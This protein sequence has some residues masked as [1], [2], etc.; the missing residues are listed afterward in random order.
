MKLSI[1]QIIKKWVKRL[2]LLGLLFSIFF[3]A[4][5]VFRDMEKKYARP[6]KLIF[7]LPL[8]ANLASFHEVKKNPKIDKVIIAGFFSNWDPKDGHFRMKPAGKG[9]WSITLRF[10]PGENQYKYVVYIKGRKQ[11]VWVHDESNPDRVQDGFGGFNSVQVIPNVKDT[12]FIFNVAVL[13]LAFLLLLYYLIEPLLHWVLRLKLAFRFKLVA[14]MIFIVIFS[15]ILFIGY[16][17]IESR[18][19]IK[20]G[21]I[22]SLNMVHLVL[23]GEGINFDKLAEKRTQE[24]IRKTVKKFFWNAR[25][26]VEKNKHSNTQVSLSDIALLDTRFR[27]LCLMNRK[28]NIKQQ[29]ARAG[30]YGFKSKEEFFLKGVLGR[31]VSAAKKSG[32]VDRI[33]L[34]KSAER[35]L[36]HET[37]KTKNAISFL[38]YNAFLHPIMIRG[39]L[40]GYYGGSIQVK[41]FGSELKRILWFNLLLLVII[42]SLA[43]M[44]LVSVGRVITGYLSELAAWTKRII[45][46]DFQ[47]AKTINSRDEIQLLAENFDA[48][49]KSL[50][51][52]FVKIEKSNTRLRIEAFVDHMTGLPN[53]QKLL[54]DLIHQEHEALLLFNID[55]FRGLN[56]FFGSDIGDLI[57]I[58]LA[59]RLAAAINNEELGLYK[60][61]ADD[62]VI[63]VSNELSKKEIEGL[64]A[65]FCDKAMDDAYRYLENEIYISVTCGIALYQQGAGKDPRERQSILNRADLALRSAKKNMLRHLVFDPSMEIK[66]EYEYNIQWIKKLKKAIREDRLVPFFQPIIN[67]KNKKVEKFECLVR[68]VE[69]DGS[70]ILPGQFLHV[71]KKARFYRFITRIMFEKSFLAFKDLPYEFSINVSMEDIM[72]HKTIAYLL[73]KLGGNPEIADRLI[74]E[75]VETAEIESYDVVKEF[76]NMVKRYGC[77]IAID[78]FGAGYSNFE[79]IMRLNI[80]FLKIDASL[81]RNMDTDENSQIITRTI[82]KFAKELGIK[83]IA[84]FVH[85]DSIYK[86]TMEY[87]IDYSQGYFFGKPEAE[88]RG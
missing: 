12:A 16:H 26:R 5:G 43:F 66:R 33:R 42:S 56:D 88:I 41:L 17:F 46:G 63:A 18:H 20:Q 84:E 29:D 2:L 21:I 44:L 39:R 19:L 34:G 11:A 1:A 57:L 14:S 65:R 13:G 27:L 22:D 49:R 68:L 61:G 52:S 45:Q 85:A 38:G 60:I 69:K 54:A 51:E 50:Q 31:L 71:S 9:R 73:D 30:T 10:A 86:K 79:H 74:L 8:P 75:I 82:S 40:L 32:P 62:F 36:V 6:R 25:V 67:N 24:R 81:I 53:R 77:R 72:D 15:N 59:K 76:I 70:I 78:D 83:T 23:R 4:G 3:I 35:F 28:Q 58:E 48:M 87:N 55:S 7:R 47:M 80:D 37:P 64:A